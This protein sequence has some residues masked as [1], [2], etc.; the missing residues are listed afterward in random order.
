MYT[1]SGLNFMIYITLILIFIAS[2]FQVHKSNNKLQVDLIQTKNNQLAKELTTSKKLVNRLI[3]E[4]INLIKETSK[5]MNYQRNI[6]SKYQRD[7][8]W[9]KRRMTFG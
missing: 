7:T 6:I 1:F 3:E 5:H 2:L 9:Y 8:K 4:K